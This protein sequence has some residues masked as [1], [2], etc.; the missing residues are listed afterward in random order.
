MPEGSRVPR[1]FGEVVSTAWDVP[2]FIESFMSSPC[3]VNRLHVQVPSFSQLEVFLAANWF[4][5]TVRRRYAGLAKALEHVTETWPDHFRITDLSPEQLGVEDWEEV[6]LRLMQRG[7]PSAAVGDIL[8][9]IFPYLTEMR[10]DDVFLG[11][12]IEIY[13]MIPYISRNR[14][15]TPELIMKEA[16]RYGADRQELEYHFRR[17]KPPRGPYRGALVLTFKNPED[18]AFTWRSRRVT[19]GWLRVPVRS[20]QVNITTKLEVWINYN[21]AFRGYWLA[22]MYL[23]A[24]GMSKR[25]RRDVPPE[26]AAEWDELG[27]RLGDVA[28]RQGAK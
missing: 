9:G 26:I 11:D 14:E 15:M 25:S 20:P 18:P 10:R 27:K 7:Y 19:S 6:F 22:Q 8:R 23:L 17:R 21:V 13:F 16:L 24:S 3:V 12:E 2:D 4:D 28:S 1:Y 5:G